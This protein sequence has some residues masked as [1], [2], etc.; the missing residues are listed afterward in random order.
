[1]KERGWGKD[2]RVEEKGEEEK[3]GGR[4]RGKRGVNDYYG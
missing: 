2:R 4:E 3:K 1:M